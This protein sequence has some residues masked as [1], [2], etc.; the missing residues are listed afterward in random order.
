MTLALF[1]A[2]DPPRRRGESH[3]NIPIGHRSTRIARPQMPRKFDVSLSMSRANRLERHIVELQNGT[4]F[5]GSKVCWTI[6]G[7]GL[8]IT[9][10]IG[11][12]LGTI[13]LSLLPCTCILQSK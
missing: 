5:V 11:V 1:L 8:H 13:E 4:K 2:V 7:G 12:T 3:G 9:G 10:A 6:S